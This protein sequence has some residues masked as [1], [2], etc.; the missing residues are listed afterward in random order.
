MIKR[1]YLVYLELELGG[2]RRPHCVY[3]HCRAAT[4]RGAAGCTACSQLILVSPIL[5]GLGSEVA[6][7]LS[8]NSRTRV[9]ERASS[10]QSEEC[11]SAH[12][13]SAHL[14]FCRAGAASMPSSGNC[15]PFPRLNSPSSCV[16][17]VFLDGRLRAKAGL[18]IGAHACCMDAQQ[19][20]LLQTL[21]CGL[22]ADGTRRIIP[23]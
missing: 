22:V 10:G 11:Q 15:V 17:A 8:Q 1:M 21:C 3:G 5:P 14:S 9:F 13:G 18:T 19:V 20:G 12:L 6:A 4:P 2:M 23:D 16:Q 7:W